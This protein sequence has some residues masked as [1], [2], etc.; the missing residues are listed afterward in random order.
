MPFREEGAHQVQ[1][2]LRAQPVLLVEHQVA[3]PE[4]QIR[5]HQRL[6]AHAGK[7]VVAPGGMRARVCFTRKD[8]PEEER[9]LTKTLM[10]ASVLAE[11]RAR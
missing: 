6:G 10:G 5:V 4:V 9:P 3:V 1:D 8:F 2:L 11:S 7:L